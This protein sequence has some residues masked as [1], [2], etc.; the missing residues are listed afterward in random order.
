M[1]P[2]CRA[3]FLLHLPAAVPGT[4]ELQHLEVTTVSHKSRGH[5]LCLR[6]STE[7]GLCELYHYSYTASCWQVSPASQTDS[8]VFLQ[9]GGTAQPSVDLCFPL[10]DFIPPSCDSFLQED[11]VFTDTLITR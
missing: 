2:P 1:A 10:D 7:P 9:M 6:Y 4:G 5:C 3:S 8:R 11:C